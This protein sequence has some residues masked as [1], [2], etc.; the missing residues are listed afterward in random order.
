MTFWMPCDRE[1]TTQVALPYVA[2]VGLLLSQALP[3]LYK[4]IST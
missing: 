1:N 2:S 4:H 3:V